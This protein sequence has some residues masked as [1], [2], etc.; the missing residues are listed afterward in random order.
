MSD[1]H[2]TYNKYSI[3]SS[4]PCVWYQ[5]L[6]MYGH[7]QYKNSLSHTCLLTH[8]ALCTYRRPQ[9]PTGPHGKHRWMSNTHKATYTHTIN[10]LSLSGTQVPAGPSASCVPL[11]WRHWWWGC[12]RSGLCWRPG[13]Q[14]PPAATSYCHR[15]RSSQWP[16]PGKYSTRWKTES[17]TGGDDVNLSFEEEERVIH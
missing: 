8:I 12:D 7:V 13:V 3:W 14:R 11:S 1:D 5:T 4:R 15:H 9:T 2:S 16:E 6:W 17:K 10:T